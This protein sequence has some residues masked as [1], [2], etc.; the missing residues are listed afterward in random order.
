[1][2]DTGLFELSEHRLFEQLVV[3]RKFLETFQGNGVVVFR[4][5]RHPGVCQRQK[6]VNVQGRQRGEVSTAMRL[7]KH[8]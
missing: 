5:V 2:T 1:L 7:P 8:S 4:A 6:L 3:Q